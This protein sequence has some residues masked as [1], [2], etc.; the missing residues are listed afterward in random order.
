MGITKI[1]VNNEPLRDNSFLAH[2]GKVYLITITNPYYESLQIERTFQELYE[3]PQQLFTLSQGEGK[4]NFSIHPEDTYISVYQLVE[5]QEVPLF[6]KPKKVYQSTLITVPASD[7]LYLTVQKEGYKEI[8]SRFFS[9]RNNETVNKIFTLHKNKKK[10]SSSS[11]VFD[12]TPYEHDM[13]QVPG[14]S[15]LI[16]RYEVSYEAFTRF[17]NASDIAKLNQD[18]KGHRL[19]GEKIFNYIMQKP[20][21]YYVSKTYKDYP[22]NYVSWYGA[23]AYTVWLS[24]QTSKSYTL[25]SAQQWRNTAKIGFDSG[26]VSF[27]AN[28]HSGVLLQKGLKSPNTLGIYDLFGNVF[29]WTTTAKGKQKHIIK[30]GSYRSKHSFLLPQKQSTA[31]SKNIH[32]KDLGFRIIK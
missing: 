8:R 30:G 4:I 23:K 20:E 9:V 27:Q 18:K 25:P 6:K 2:K 32:R 1:K 14:Q 11:L 7:K 28:Y 16:S 13:I 15:F 10:T 21:G 5:D 24:K 22:I 3:N 29:E 12:S 19:Y 31:Y 26:Q 17:L